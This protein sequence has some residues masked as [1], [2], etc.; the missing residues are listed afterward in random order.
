MNA[1][2]A[3]CAGGVLL[4][5]TASVM[6]VAPKPVA[7][8]TD[9]GQADNSQPQTQYGQPYESETTRQ[10]RMLYAKDGKQMPEMN[11]RKMP[12]VT[13]SPGLQ[14]L[15]PI[16]PN[17]KSSSPVGFFKR[18]FS[19]GRESSRPRTYYPPQ[20]RRPAARY[21]PPQRPVARQPAAT[22]GYRAPSYGHVSP[23]RTIAP[24]PQRRIQA[25][26]VSATRTVQVQ[27]KGDEDEIPV[28]IDERPGAPAPRKTAATPRVVSA[29]ANANRSAARPFPNRPGLDDDRPQ[30][31]RPANRDDE[32]KADG[33]SNPF[34]GRSLTDDDAGTQQKPAAPTPGAKAE[35]G[36]LATRSTAPLEI[37]SFQQIQRNHLKQRHPLAEPKVLG[38]PGRAAKAITAHPPAAPSSREEKQ[39]RIAERRGMTGFRGFCPVMLR[40]RRELADAKLKFQSRYRNKTYYF[41]SAR[42]KATFERA[43]QKYAPVS[44][45]I[46]IVLFTDELKQEE[47][48]LEHA[49]WFH[50]RLYFFTGVKTLRK[51]V[52]D[53]K[54]YAIPE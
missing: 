51:F 26:N 29:P 40:D 37:K 13:H 24:Q 15:R 10:L 28:L 38:T 42:A 23:P 32:R 54:D 27:K 14:N 34:T 35:P 45:G 5:A 39:R 6:V 9:R 46:D 12:M 8:Q 44:S 25:F 19:L 16:D 49:V 47:G 43:P 33:D 48:S 1:R 17:K 7:G 52:N 22:P 30:L 41:S 20:Y 18:L 53:P 36:K 11:V 21:Y 3:L 31:P 50:G 4:C 2:I